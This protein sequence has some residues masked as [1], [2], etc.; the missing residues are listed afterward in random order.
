MSDLWI[1]NIQESHFHW[2]YE[3]LFPKD[4]NGTVLLQDP[5]YLVKLKNLLTPEECKKVLEI[6]EG[7]YTRSTIFHDG[8]LTKS[9]NRTSQTAYLTE[10]GGKENKHSVLETI[11]K[12]VCILT[13]CQ[14]TQVEGLMIVKYE[15]GDEFQEHWDYFEPEKD[16]AALENGGQRIATF[17]VW[18]ND[19]EADDGGGT[20][21]PKVQLYCLPDRGAALFWWNQYGDKLIKETAHSGTPVFK[22]IKYGMNIWIRYPGWV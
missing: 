17:F 7:K 6:A 15:E 5:F 8:K 3:D 16:D 22:G 2:L 18:L 1:D 19:M 10:N 9:S 4:F 12:R 21:F 14:R 13:G 11:F 20:Y